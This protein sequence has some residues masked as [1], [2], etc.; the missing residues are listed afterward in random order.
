MRYLLLLLFLLNACSPLAPI[1]PE[2]P[3]LPVSYRAEQPAHAE[4]LPDHWWESFGD[5]QLNQLQQQLLSSNLDLR[6]ALYRI[7]QLEALQ[8]ASAA[9]LWPS[10]TLS[11]SINRDKTPGSSNPLISSNQRVSLAASYEVDL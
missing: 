3:E 6:Q 9:G 4:T 2:Q 1:Q 5:P 11:G 10:L 7:E 8:R